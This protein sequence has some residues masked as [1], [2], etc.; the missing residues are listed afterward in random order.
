MRDTISGQTELTRKSNPLTELSEEPPLV[1][2]TSS[3]QA[4]GTKVRMSA[5]SP[6]RPWAWEIRFLVVTNYKGENQIM[7]VVACTEVAQLYRIVLQS[8]KYKRLEYNRL[9]Y[10][11]LEYSA[12]F[13]DTIQPCLCRGVLWWSWTLP[14]LPRGV[15]SDCRSVD[16][17]WE[18]LY[19][20]GLTPP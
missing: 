11:R 19:P 8:E 12:S 13:L 4:L 9:E 18:P 7:Y 16:S 5:Y 17:W 3:E 6:P 1:I 2:L 15:Q 20:P 14:P 10:K